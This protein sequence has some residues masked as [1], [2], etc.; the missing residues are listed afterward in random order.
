[1][2]SGGSGRGGGGGGGG[3]AKSY[4]P[5][6]PLT[7]FEGGNNV[8]QKPDDGVMEHLPQVLGEVALLHQLFAGVKMLQYSVQ[9]TQVIRTQDFHHLPWKQI[10][11]HGIPT[12]GI[13]GAY[14][15]R[16]T[17]WKVT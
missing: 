15:P 11:G 7:L 3:Q 12:F 9:S 10:K 14:V 2:H 16:N 1:M 8:P 13:S 4:L 17:V 6:L 5:P